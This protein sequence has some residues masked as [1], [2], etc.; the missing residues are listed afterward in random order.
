MRAPEARILVSSRDHAR[1]PYGWTDI[2]LSREHH[3]SRARQRAF[4]DASVFS[5]HAAGMGDAR[6][7]I[8]YIG[9]VLDDDTMGAA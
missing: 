7:E 4:F 9:Y 8:G 5:A 2:E 1:A 6:L 3:V